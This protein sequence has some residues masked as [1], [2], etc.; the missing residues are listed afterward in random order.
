MTLIVTWNLSKH[1]R[2]VIKLDQISDRSFANLTQ[3]AIDEGA[4]GHN[5]CTDQSSLF[6]GRLSGQGL[7]VTPDLAH[8]RDAAHQV[9][10]RMLL[11]L[12][13][14]VHVHE[15]GPRYAP[16]ASITA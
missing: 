10:G 2:H 15:T 11:D 8:G 3:L 5:T 13:M 16:L 1:L 9:Q 12:Q 4:G 14:D 6:H 7:R